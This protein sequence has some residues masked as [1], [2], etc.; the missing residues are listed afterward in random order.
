MAAASRTITFVTG[1]AKKLEEFRRILGPDFPHTVVSSGL[2]LPEY[3]GTPQEVVTEKC[4][5]AARRVEGPVI[6]EDTSLCFSALGGLPGP[7]IKWFLGALGPEGLPR[8]IK[9]WDDKSAAAL[10]LFGYCG[11]EGGEVKVFEGRTEGVIVS[12]PRGA[13]DFGWDPIFQPSGHELTYAELEPEI[14][15]AIS[16]RGRAMAKLTHFLTEEHS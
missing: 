13:R 6:V 3:Q 9:D 2:D 15:N 5:E 8:M 14:K 1:N 10:C 7:Y 4:R 16:H 12:P 11:G